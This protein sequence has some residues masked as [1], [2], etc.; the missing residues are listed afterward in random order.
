VQTPKVFQ[1]DKSAELNGRAVVA[2]FLLR[3]RR[4]E[5]IPPYEVCFSLKRAMNHR[6]YNVY[7][8]FL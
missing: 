6:P 5:V 4:D 2:P 1:Y 8:N 3:N 7:R